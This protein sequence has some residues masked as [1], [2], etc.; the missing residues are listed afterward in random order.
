MFA[1]GSASSEISPSL[2]PNASASPHPPAPLRPPRQLW[3][4]NVHISR[5]LPA[6]LQRCCLEILWKILQ[7]TNRLS[8]FS[9]PRSSSAP[10]PTQLSCAAVFLPLPPPD[11]L[12]FAFQI[13][14]F[15]MACDLEKGRI[16][17][18]EKSW[19]LIDFWLNPE[20]N[21]SVFYGIFCDHAFFSLIEIG[22]FL[23]DPELT[24]L[25]PVLISV[26]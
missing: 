23:K 7:P 22:I 25:G 6:V 18:P 14:Y 19:C 11:F 12:L 15:N 20:G 16:K 9:L 1:F 3:V 24:P 13:Y 26:M 8:S 2:L 21:Y 5:R 10:S 4:L 17:Y